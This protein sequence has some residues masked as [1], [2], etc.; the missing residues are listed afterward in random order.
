MRRK[1]SEEAATEQ[2]PDTSLRLEECEKVRMARARLG[3]V[4]AMSFALPSSCMLVSSHATVLS[5]LPMPLSLAPVF[6][7]GWP[8]LCHSIAG[9]KG[10]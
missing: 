10:G 7:C 9:K 4:S 8:V 3:L 2:R 5:C 1:A 6:G